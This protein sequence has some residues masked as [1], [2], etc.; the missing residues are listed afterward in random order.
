[1]LSSAMKILENISPASKKALMDYFV[2]EEEEVKA[3]EA[4]MQER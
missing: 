3:K 4:L 1:M 2:E